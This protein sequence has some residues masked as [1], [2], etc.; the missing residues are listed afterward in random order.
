M[1][2]RHLILRRGRVYGPALFNLRSLDPASRSVEAPAIVGLKDDGQDRGIHF[3]GLN[4]SIKGQFEF[5]QQSWAN[6]PGFNGLHRN[7]DPLIGNP[8]SPGALD[9]MQIPGRGLD[10]RTAPLPLFVTVRAGAYLFLPSLRALRFL[11]RIGARPG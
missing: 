5:I 8:A 3:I 2:A 10:L 9:A 7:R 6:H 4:A 11:S 1:T